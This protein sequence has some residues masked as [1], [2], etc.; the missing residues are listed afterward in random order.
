MTLT[1]TISDLSAEQSVLGAVFLDP[2]VLDEISFLEDRDFLD[3]RHQQIYRVMRWL[4]KRNKPVDVVTVTEMYVQHNRADELSVTYLTELAESCPT[5]ANVVYHANIVRSKAIR[6]RGSEIGNKITAL[7]RE[8]F[9]TD[10]EYF[11]AVEALVAEMRPDDNGKMRSLVETRQKYFEHLLSKEITYIESGFPQFDGW[12]KG[13]YR[14]D[15]FISAG[16]PS[17]GKTAMLLQRVIGVA[18][19]GP[20]L[21]WSQ[22]MDEDQLKDR[23]ISNITGI[24]FNRIRNKELSPKQ[25]AEVEEAYNRLEQLPIYIQ[26][27]SGVTIEEV[28]STARR[29]KRK[30]GDLAMVAVDYLQIMKIP[31]PKGRTRAEAIGKVTQAAKQMAREM[32]CVFMMLSQMTRD[33]DKN[34]KKPTLSELKESGSIEQDADVVEFLWL[35]PNDTEQ[36]G[37]V[38]QQFIAKG[39]NTGLNEFRLLFR[40]WKQQFIELDKKKS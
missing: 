32:K 29:F 4:D 40:G 33:S 39:R 30:H 10:E 22:E 2:N 25:Y 12:A 5:T 21:I 14:G 7:S 23:M 1:G 27:S 37:K 35:D 36:Q 17:V 3:H 16:R 11:S 20:V 15:L 38:V 6:R 19:S 28:R 26:D 9:E 24:P 13:L 34:P 18:E 8:D 31:Q